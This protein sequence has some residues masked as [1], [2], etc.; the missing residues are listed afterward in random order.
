MRRQYFDFILVSF[1]PAVVTSQQSLPETFKSFVRQLTTFFTTTT[2]KQ[3]CFEPPP[4]FKVHLDYIFCNNITF[5]SNVSLCYNYDKPTAYWFPTRIV[6]NGNLDV[7]VL[8]SRAVQA[9]RVPEQ[10]WSTTGVLVTQPSSSDLNFIEMCFTGHV[11]VVLM[12]QI[13]TLEV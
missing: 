13:C 10:V 11:R 8:K 2:E 9:S 3:K 7:R 1:W 4:L 12:L 5:L 6:L